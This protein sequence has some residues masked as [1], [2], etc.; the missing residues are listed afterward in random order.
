MKSN[1]RYGSAASRIRAIVLVSMLVQA[2]TVMADDEP[3]VRL[4]PGDRVLVTV[5]GHEDLSGEFE[6]N[7]MGRLTLPLVQNVQAQGV[8]TNELEQ[9]II[10]KLQPDY[11]INPRVTVQLLS[12]RPFYI[13]GEVN[14]PGS[15]PFSG[16][17]TVV[18]AV[19][20]A[21]GYTHRAREKRIVIKRTVD[22]E[23]VEIPA[24]AETEIMP[25]DVI[26]VPERFF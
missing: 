26:E 5:F 21:G 19:A 15:Y 9:L 6:I 3:E 20:V 8:T 18:N 4:G 2:G 14:A 25:G 17:M 12:F 1:T 7:T 23:Q 13:L 16:G 24:T 11:L 22:G 10:D